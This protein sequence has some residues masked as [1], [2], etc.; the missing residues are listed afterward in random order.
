[1]PYPIIDSHCHLDSP[2]FNRDRDEVLERARKAG[3]FGMINSGTSRRGNQIS[4]ELAEKH[5]A[6]HACLGLSPEL[7]RT[8]SKEDIKAVLT[9]I[10]TKADQAVAIGEAGL[11]YQ[12]CKNEEEKTRQEASFK[13]V[14]ELAKEFEKPL[15]VHARQAEPEVLALVRGLETVVYHCYSGTVETLRD[16]LDSG[17]Y[18]SLATLVCFS[19]HHQKLAAKVPLE[20]LLLETDSPYLSPRRGR[21]EPAYVAD[22]IPVI[23]KVKETEASEIAN[24]ATKNARR[25]FKI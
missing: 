19:D 21:N 14:I 10:E 2:K 8:G 3:V 12:D 20:N 4:L 22:S 13:K 7:G 23:A 9:Q 25:V 17:Y 16:I 1:M 5:E 15:V 18:I 24:A 11:D 6:I